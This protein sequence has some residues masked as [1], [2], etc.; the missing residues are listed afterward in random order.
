[1]LL[2]FA[3]PV[4]SVLKPVEKVQI[5]RSHPGGR[6]PSAK[7]MLLRQV[8]WSY[9]CSLLSNSSHLCNG[10]CVKYTDM[11]RPVAK[12]RKMRILP[13]ECHHS[14]TLI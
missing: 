14:E 3:N 12:R 5:W 1:M 4:L 8:N 11:V 2:N 10:M 9:R 6:F 13:G 7:I